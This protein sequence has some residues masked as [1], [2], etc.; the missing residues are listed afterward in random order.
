MGKDR[1]DDNPSKCLKS[2]RNRDEKGIKMLE[3]MTSC[4]VYSHFLDL[5]MSKKKFLKRRSN[6]ITKSSV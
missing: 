5:D 6:Q 1:T 3:A 2:F 4:T